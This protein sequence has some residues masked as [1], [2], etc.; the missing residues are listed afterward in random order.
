MT[1]TIPRRIRYRT[2]LWLALLPLAAGCEGAE[3]PDGDPSG[4]PE[5]GGLVAKV[6]VQDE[7]GPDPGTAQ[8][9]ADA[10]TLRYVTTTGYS[11]SCPPVAEASGDAEAVVLRIAE[12]PATSERPCT[13]DARLVTV[14]VTGLPRSPASLEVTEA[15]STAGS[16][17]TVRIN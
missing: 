1:P 15:G 11:S 12:D 14:S 13:R 3:Q 10:A 8:W 5:A 7:P 2:L 17:R 4:S 9:N 6:R 16:A